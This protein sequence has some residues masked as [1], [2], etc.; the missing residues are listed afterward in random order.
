MVE[1]LCGTVE[2]IGISLVG[3]PDFRQIDQIGVA[4]IP[5]RGDH[6]FARRGPAAN[7]PDHVHV[8]VAELEGVQVSERKNV[9]AWLIAEP[10]VD[11]GGEESSASSA[12]VTPAAPTS[13]VVTSGK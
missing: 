7:S 13:S 9:F 1:S 6:L 10:A 2:H 3:R 8:T 12:P 5:G 11:Q 4:C